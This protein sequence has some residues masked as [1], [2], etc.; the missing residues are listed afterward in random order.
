MARTI[1]HGT[2]GSTA[3]H[4]GFRKLD[5]KR[6]GLEQL[7]ANE[8]SNIQRVR[9]RWRMYNWVPQSLDKVEMRELAYVTDVRRG[10]L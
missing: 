3:L 10:E 5:Y 2:G 4:N 6:C 7:T 9:R 8:R 1:G